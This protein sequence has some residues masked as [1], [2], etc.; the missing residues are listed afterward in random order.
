MASLAGIEWTVVVVL[1]TLIGGIVAIIR[2]IAPIVNS[3][4]T[5]TNSTKSLQ[6]SIEESIKLNREAHY[7]I[8]DS[9]ESEREKTANLDKRL[10]VLEQKRIRN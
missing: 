10:A 9:I 4:A 5:L 8:W 3:I 1:I 6:S 7:R 2:T